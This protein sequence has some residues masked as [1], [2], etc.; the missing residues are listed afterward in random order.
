MSGMV[1]KYCRVKYLGFEDYVQRIAGKASQRM[2]VVKKML[3]LS[4]KP[5][6]SMMFKSFVVSLLMYCLPVLHTSICTIDKK[7]LRKVFNV[8][9]NLRLDVG[10]LDIIVVFC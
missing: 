3:H 4:T 2:Y 8:A 6:A 9:K 1:P 10:D 5:L 7:L